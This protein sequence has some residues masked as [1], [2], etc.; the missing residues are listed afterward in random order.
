M[1]Q[2]DLEIR[3]A[4]NLLGAN[5]SGFI[6]AVGFDLYVSLL[7]KEVDMLRQQEG[8]LGA[9]GAGGGAAADQPLDI[10]PEINLKIAALI[11]EEYIQDPRFRVGFYRR[12][13][14]AKD[15]EELAEV[16]DELRDRFGVLPGEVENLVQV[17]LLKRKLQKLGVRDLSFDGKD[18]VLMFDPRTRV[19]PERLVR[20]AAKEP[21]RYKLTPEQ[22][23]KMRVTS[24]EAIVSEAKA[25]LE[26]LS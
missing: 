14:S 6:N 15:D 3:G 16:R 25:L 2:R 8:G 12:L 20:M 13:S 19:N 22:R 17:L 10:E 4:G 5:Q 11:P 9:N 7:K 24:R 18:L 21:K 23:F 1:A 26:L